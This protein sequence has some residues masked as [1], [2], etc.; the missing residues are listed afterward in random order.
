MMEAFHFLLF[1]ARPAS[2]RAEQG[3]GSEDVMTDAE[4]IARILAGN[5]RLF[6]ELVERHAGCVWAICAGH[7]FNRHECEDVAQEV[8]VQGYLK[9]NTLR[10]AA[11]FGSWL[12]EIARRRCL[13][14]NRAAARRRAATE[15]Y[16]EHV[17]HGQKSDDTADRAARDDLHRAIRGLMQSLPS[18]TREALLLCYG[19]GYSVR[20]A[21]KILE[22]SPNTL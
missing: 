6:G 3:A 11:A 4:L 17:Q 8:F 22:V 9:L 12:C 16:A 20:D 7:V 18:K 15:R 21:A 5:E 13:E 10:N 1:S 14:W 2:P 19:E